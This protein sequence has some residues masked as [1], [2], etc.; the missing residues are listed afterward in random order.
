MASAQWP[1]LAYTSSSVLKVTR[2]GA[3]PSDSICGA[4][5][6]GGT[7]RGAGGVGASLG[8]GAAR[9]ARARL[10]GGQGRQA[11]GRSAP[12]SE[13]P[14]ARLRSHHRPHAPPPITNHLARPPLLS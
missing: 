13:R 8:G 3:T 11:R 6:G 4:G 7:G 10:D 9:R 5:G 1:V 14:E 12:R 2:L